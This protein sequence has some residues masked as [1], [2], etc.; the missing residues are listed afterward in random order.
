[1]N[2]SCEL[3]LWYLSSRV[4]S[5]SWERSCNK[6]IYQTSL[7]SFQQPSRPKCV[8]L[9]FHSFC[10]QCQDRECPRVC[11]RISPDI[12]FVLALPG[13]RI[14]K[15]PIGSF[16]SWKEGEPA[17][18]FSLRGGRLVF[19][20][21]K[22]QQQRRLPAEP[23]EQ[24]FLLISLL[25]YSFIVIALYIYLGLVISYESIELLLQY[26]HGLS[27][28]WLQWSTHDKLKQALK[29][30]L[31]QSFFIVHTQSVLNKHQREKKITIMHDLLCIKYETKHCSTTLSGKCLRK[32]NV[33]VCLVAF[34]KGKKG[35]RD[36]FL[37]R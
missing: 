27:S 1:M 30:F 31:R 21:E 14:E 6:F 24:A 22:H 33:S 10:A 26:V 11:L 19:G 35:M 3:R 20:R 36:Q 7:N 34:S 17:C 12:L 37:L 25:F 5:P 32:S 23:K 8:R 15:L 28:S 16:Y 29:W 4:R 9:Y 2:Q 18:S 13:A